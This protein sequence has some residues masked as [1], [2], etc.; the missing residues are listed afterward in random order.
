MFGIIA[1]ALASAGLVG[2][3]GWMSP[4]LATH[5]LGRILILAAVL[6][7]PTATVGTGVVVGMHQSSSTTFC[8]SCHEMERHGKSLFVDNGAALAAVHYQKRLIPRDQTCYACH[9]DYAMFGDIKAKMNG[10]KH[11]WV[12]YV[13]GA[14][15]K[16]A[17]YAPYPNY[18]CLH[19][20]EDA[21]SYLE[22]AAHQPIAAAL[23]SGERS[24]LTCHAVA[25]D[26]AGVDANNYWV[27]P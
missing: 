5:R 15:D 9:T 12:H 2:L 24:C 27:A 14:P 25:H 10:L 1:L 26:Q 21:R 17:L 7:V 19:C 23:S 18:N 20:H 6:L 3:V 22:V 4:N 8:L 13:N 11:V 16:L